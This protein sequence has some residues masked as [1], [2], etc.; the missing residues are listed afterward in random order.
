MSTTLIGKL[1]L[2]L[3]IIQANDEIDLAEQEDG[4]GDGDEEY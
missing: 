1:Q 2:F 3:S 4:D